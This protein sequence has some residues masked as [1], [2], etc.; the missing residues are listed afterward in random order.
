MQAGIYFLDD[1]CEDLFDPPQYC[2]K[3]AAEL[4]QDE[5]P[6]GCPPAAEPE[7]EAA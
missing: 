4:Q 6:E 3:C 2:T 5:C 1:E 7:K